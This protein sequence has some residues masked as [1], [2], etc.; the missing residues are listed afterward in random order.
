MIKTINQ[1]LKKIIF[2]YKKQEV[3]KSVFLNKKNYFFH[4]KGSHNKCRKKHD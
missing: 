4:S 1:M 2:I 3:K